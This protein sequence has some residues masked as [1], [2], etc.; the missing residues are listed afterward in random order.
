M[1]KRIL[2]VLLFLGALGVAGRYWSADFLRPSIERSLER[3]L[4]RKVEIKS[5]HLN[6]FGAP[7]FTLENVVIHEDPRAGIE[8]FAYVDS[9][10]AGIRWLSLIRRK[11]DFSSLNL[12]DA[13]INL[14]KTS[15]G[16]WNFQMLLEAAGRNQLFPAIRIRG[17]RVNFKFGDTKSVFFFDNADFDVNPYGR[18]A[19]ELRFGGAPSRTDRPA[20]EF[21]YFFVRG[22]WN[23]QAGPRLD[24]SVELERSSLDEFSRLVDTHGFGLHGVIALQAQLSGPPNDLQM[25]G[26]FQVGDVHR[27]DLLPQGGAWSVPFRGRMDLASGRVELASVEDSTSP[28]TLGFKAWDVLSIPAWAADV[29]LNQMPLATLVEVARHL[30]AA[31]PEDL[32]A[33]GGVSGAVSYTEQGGLSGKVELRDAALTLPNAETFRTSFAPVAL[34]GGTLYME[35]S[36]VEIGPKQSIEVEAAYQMQAP[37]ELDLRISTRGLNIADM[38]SFSVAAI[39]LL[40]H[41]QQGSWR[42]WARFRGGQW[43]G[44]YEV[45]NARVPVEGIAGAVRIQSAAVRLNGANAT[46]TRM[47]GTAGDIAFTGEYRWEAAALRPHKFKLNVAE[48]DASAIEQLLAP[49]L[50]RERGFLARTLRLGAAAPPAWLKSRRAD[51]TIS[52]GT[53]NVGDSSVTLDQARLLWDGETVRLVNA[54]GD[55]DGAPFAGDALISLEDRQ[56]HYRYTGTL[57]DVPYKG[58]KLDFDGNLEADGSGDALLDSVQAEGDVRGRAVSFAPDADFRTITGCFELRG[59][60]WKLSTVEVTQGAE[61]YTGSGATQADGRLALDL[62]RGARQLRYV[63][64]Q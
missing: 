52:I 47:R 58:G 4:G 23:P 10:N 26:Q 28:V 60:R 39:P 21:G 46:V 36:S 5:V 64:S 2:I 56:P 13:T 32:T 3:G 44:E 55:I 59:S 35:N 49:T 30:G 18:G 45:Q 48:A 12:G 51:G 31:L 11:L 38:P 14:A 57:S 43:S 42:G 61:S 33:E 6:L 37:R 50:I 53:L 40:N 19:V 63:A 20:R 16:P 22:N 17:G 29:H 8:P 54:H 7:G 27:W 24:L 62:M 15:A 1:I 25:N 9:L 41:M 34:S